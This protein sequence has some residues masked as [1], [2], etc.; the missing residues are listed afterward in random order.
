[1]SLQKLTKDWTEQDF[2][3]FWEWTD[4][5]LKHKPDE[6]WF[7]VDIPNRHLKAKDGVRATYME[8]AVYKKVQEFD[9]E[10]RLKRRWY[11]I[12]MDETLTKETANQ[13]NAFFDQIREKIDLPNERLLSAILWA[14]IYLKQY[15]HDASLESV[16]L[17]EL[18]DSTFLKF[19]LR[20]IVVL[21]RVPE[22]APQETNLI[23]LPLWQ[24]TS[25]GISEKRIIRGDVSIEVMGNFGLPTLFT[26][27]IAMVLQWIW[28]EQGQSDIFYTSLSEGC[29][30]I[31]IPADHKNRNLV[32]NAIYQLHNT[33]FNA[34]LWIKDEKGKA[35]KKTIYKINVVQIEAQEIK[36]G[37]SHTLKLRLNEY[38]ADNLKRGRFTLLD[39]KKIA[40]LSSPTAKRL[41]SIIERQ[42]DPCFKRRLWKLKDLLVLRGK[43]YR[44]SI[45][46]GAQ[47][48]IDTGYL[49]KYKIQPGK[50]TPELVFRAWKAETKNT[51][52]SIKGG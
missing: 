44:Q 10:H 26:F 35:G 34:P 36:P 1:L 52:S 3:K 51:G 48:L 6:W 5:R 25:R 47:E 13:L 30:R 41:Y 42:K 2:K 20:G 22:L 14:V 17:K 12:L 43:R 15:C 21:E 50:S 32:L 18:L 45:E 33:W 23:D 46:K 11:P 28:Q 7:M 31:G 29:K 40:S 38:L 9:K 19:L 16:K 4:K 37:R 8:L 24:P 39:I 27:E 49:E